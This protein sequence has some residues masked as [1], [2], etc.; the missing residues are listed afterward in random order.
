MLFRSG[1]DT[2][3]IQPDGTTALLNDRPPLVLTATAS[4][5]GSDTSLPFTMVV[6]HLRSLLSIDDPV[7]GSRVR[8]KREAQAEFLA[9]LLQSHQAAGENVVSVCDCNSFE[10]SDGYVDVLGTIVGHPVPADQVVLASPDLVDPDFTDLVTTLPHDQQYSYDFNGS[11]QVLDHVV[12]SQSL[13]TQLSRFAIARNDADFPEVFR[14]DPNRPERISDHDM[15]VAYFTLPE[16]TPPVLHLPANITAEATGPGGAVVSYSATATDARDTD[17]VV[18]CTPASGSLFP[19]GATTVN[20]S[21]TNSRHKTAEGSFA[22]TVVDTTAPVVSLN[23]VTDGTVY[24]LGAVPVASC[25]TTDS[26]SGVATQATFSITGGTANGVGHFTATCS[27]AK[28]NAGNIAA[29]L[30]AS[31]DVQY[32]FTGFFSPVTNGKMFKI[33]S[34]I[35]LKWQLQNAQQGYLSTFSSIVAVQAAPDPAC[36]AG[37]EGVPLDINAAGNSGLQFD[38]NT[39]QFNWKTSGLVAGCYD[40]MVSLDDGTRKTTFI[41]L[42]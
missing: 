41:T 23:G 32:V 25:S 31:Y 29:P 18:T 8:A 19:L 13:M 38:Q 27:G 37:D 39:F 16:P 33:G 6:N 40:V 24:I 2:T 11:H 36:L 42:R 28:D 7:D 17:V 21:A 9:N 10:F 4:Q 22:I 20:C 3:F 34:T 26:A 12:V 30:S 35:P 1:K 5:P 14:N 15:P